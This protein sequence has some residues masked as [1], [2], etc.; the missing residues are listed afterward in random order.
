MRSTKVSK[1]SSSGHRLV[2]VQSTITFTTTPEV[3]SAPLAAA[4]GSILLSSTVGKGSIT[5]L[6]ACGVGR[7]V[8]EGNFEGTRE[9]RYKRLYSAAS[10][11][12]STTF[13]I[14]GIP[15]GQAFEFVGEIS[16]VDNIH[17]LFATD[18]KS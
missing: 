4:G 6:L 17:V 8:F 16:C 5:K 3:W 15:S 1:S 10:G 7:V 11:A 2:Y 9:S 14:S 18:L 13:P 12:P